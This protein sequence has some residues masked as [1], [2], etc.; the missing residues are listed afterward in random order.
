M[1]KEQGCLSETNK[2]AHT[3]YIQGVTRVTKHW[4]SNTIK[5]AMPVGCLFNLYYLGNEWGAQRKGAKGAILAKTENVGQE[6]KNGEL[7]LSERANCNS[8]ASW[9]LSI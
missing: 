1:V 7:I 6:K 3:F 8:M 9:Y 2:T 4:E 5:G